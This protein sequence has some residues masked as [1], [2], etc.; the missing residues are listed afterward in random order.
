MAE[1]R[2][3]LRWLFVWIIASAATFGLVALLMAAG[4]VLRYPDGAIDWANLRF[5]AQ[6]AVGV[7]L[8]VA[9]LDWA[10]RAATPGERRRRLLV[11][12]IWAIFLGAAFGSIFLLILGTA[13]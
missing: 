6:L 12:G 13:S 11:T 4:G 3:T 10:L 9:L 5:A 1:V 2:G 7:G 8:I